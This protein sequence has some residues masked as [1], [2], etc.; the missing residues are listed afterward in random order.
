MDFSFLEDWDRIRVIPDSRK[1]E[2]IS[3]CVVFVN[4]VR[5]ISNAVSI[6]VNSYVVAPEVSSIPLSHLLREFSLETWL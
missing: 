6:F 2:W 5:G 3:V 1:D 4:Y